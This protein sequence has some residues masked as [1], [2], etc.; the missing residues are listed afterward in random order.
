MARASDRHIY[1]LA[2]H[3]TICA[4]LSREALI[5][6]VWPEK[7]GLHLDTRTVDQHIARIRNK[8]KASG[9][10]IMTIP[11]AGYRVLDENIGFVGGRPEPIVRKVPKVGSVLHVK[12]SDLIEIK[13]GQQV[14]VQF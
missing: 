5:E 1:S 2:P 8:W 12:L 7:A 10:L 9:S 6:Q 13:P 3:T 14:L 4:M 11:N